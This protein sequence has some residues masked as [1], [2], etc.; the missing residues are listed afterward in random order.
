V[1]ITGWYIKTWREGRW[2]IR[3]M[4]WVNKDLEAEQVQIQSP[5]VTAATV[6][7]PDR[8]VLAASVYVPDTPA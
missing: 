3:G 7:L 1:N 8:I 2:A 5:D 4:L 6:R